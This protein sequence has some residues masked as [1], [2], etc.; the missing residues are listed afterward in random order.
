[1]FHATSEYTEQYF[2]QPMK[3]NPKYGEHDSLQLTL[4]YTQ[5]SE[6]VKS[7]IKALFGFSKSCL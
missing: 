7:D 1:M 3:N 2:P 6:I 5:Q 4:T